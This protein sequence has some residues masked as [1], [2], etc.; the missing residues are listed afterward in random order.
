MVPT[1]MSTCSKSFGSI[2]DFTGAGF[3]RPVWHG[4]PKPESSNMN[5]ALSSN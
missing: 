3:M 2:S 4:M 1:R 5:D